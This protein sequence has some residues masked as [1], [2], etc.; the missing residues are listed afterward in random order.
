LE[1]LHFGKSGEINACVKVLL[2]CVHGETLW[3]DPTISIDISLLAKK[4]GLPKADED[5]TILFNKVGE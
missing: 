5:P 3:L 1:I 4:T 2:I